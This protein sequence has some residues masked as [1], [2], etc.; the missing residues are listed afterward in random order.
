[1]TR[2]AVAWLLL[3]AAVVV[4]LWI[5]AG[6]APKASAP[7]HAGNPTTSTSPIRIG[8]IPERDIFAMRK[9]NRALVDYLENQLGEP[10][11]LVTASSYQVV[12][13]DF[14]Q[15]RI[16]AAFL[17]SLIAVLCFDRQDAQV[18]TKTESLDGV[19]E[20]HGVIVVP[21]SSPIRSV[22]DLERRPM[23]MVRTTLGGN[24]FPFCQFK[25]AGLLEKDKRPHLVWLGTHDDAIRAAAEGEV[26]AAAVKDTRLRAY[27]RMHPEKMLR[28][29]A[30]SGP[31]PDNALVIRQDVAKTLGPRLAEAMLAMDKTPE[32]RAVLAEYG[33][34]RFLPCERPEYEAIYDLVTELGPDWVE[35]GIDGP[36]PLRTAEATE[37]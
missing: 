35:L 18:I 11:E 16:E 20:Y 23:A 9:R 12:L 8:I 33:A 21:E 26:E 30:R 19:S 4:A 34:K 14:S 10:I 24:L 13:E 25:E 6:R 29:I 31:V 3:V 17:G 28:V 27:L 22:A 1:M 15:Q 7:A 37:R 5:I 2:S 32:G 36:A